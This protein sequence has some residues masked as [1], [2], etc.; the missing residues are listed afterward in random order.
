MYN[1]SSSDPMSLVS[2]INR[3]RTGMS[4][5]M[6][7]IPISLRARLARASREHSIP[8]LALIRT[9]IA[10][11]MDAIETRFPPS[12]LGVPIG[13]VG[14]PLPVRGPSGPV[15]CPMPGVADAATVVQPGPPEPEPEIWLVPESEP[16]PVAEP[17]PI[18]MVPEPTA[19][20]P[21]PTMVPE[22]MVQIEAPSRK[23]TRPKS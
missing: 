17:E 22:P 21:E 18:A 19:M 16:V 15:P 5:L 9:A 23:R 1:E 12:P 20:V 13:P 7:T 10:A 3:S 6:L 14:G 4:R 8:Q 11:Y 2:H